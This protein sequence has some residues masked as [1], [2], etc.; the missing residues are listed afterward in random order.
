MNN[1]VSYI[2]LGSLAL[3]WGASFLLIKVGLQA[4]A[5]AHITFARIVLGALVLLAL[6]FFRGQRLGGDSRLWKHVAV[7]ALFASALPWTLLNTGEQTVDS[8]LAGVINATTPLWTGLFGFVLGS[9]NTMSPQRWI[10]L[11]LGFTGVLV[12]FAPWQSDALSWGVLACLAASASYGIGYTYIGRHLTGERLRANGLTPLA[13]AAMQMIAA[14]GIATLAL[15]LGGLRL[16]EPAAAPLLAVAALGIFGTGIGFALNYRLIADEGATTASTVTF[17]MPVVSVALGWL[18]L[19]EQFGP[20]VLLGMV[21]V[22]AGVALARRNPPQAGDRPAGHLPAG[23]VA[24]EALVTG[25]RLYAEL[26]TNHPG[27]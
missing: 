8:G 7:A 21:I 9:R 3:L 27:K 26:A 20:R 14:S 5:P 16:P 10:G 1:P 22:L 17:L 11:G 12:I 4:L 15:P 25:T 2:R 6:V 13:L 24:R 23:P 18:V 19:D